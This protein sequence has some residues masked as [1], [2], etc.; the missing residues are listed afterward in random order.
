MKVGAEPIKRGAAA[1]H[2]AAVP[3]VPIAI[4]GTDRVMGIDNRLQR[5]SVRI[6]I[7]PALHPDPA[8]ADPVAGLMDRWRRWIDNRLGG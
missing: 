1:R 5:G 3:L 6:A 4:E 2:P 7:G 8:A